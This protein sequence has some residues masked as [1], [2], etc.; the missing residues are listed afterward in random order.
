MILRYAN[1]VQT[2]TPT[3]AKVQQTKI[4][5]GKLF[6]SICKPQNLGDSEEICIMLSWHILFLCAFYVPHIPG[7]ICWRQVS[8]EEKVYTLKKS[9]QWF[10]WLCPPMYAE[11]VKYEEYIQYAEYSEYG[12]IITKG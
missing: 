4:S 1:H 6:P 11:Y 10:T 7:S 8:G 9:L 3:C 5:H 12:Q 2:Q